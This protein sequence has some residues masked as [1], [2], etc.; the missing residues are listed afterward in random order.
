MRSATFGGVARTGDRSGG[1]AVRRAGGDRQH[2][3]PDTRQC[4]HVSDVAVE[5]A[6]VSG[7]QHG[8]HRAAECTLGSRLALL[9]RR[10]RRWARR[11]ATITY[12]MYLVGTV[13]NFCTMHASLRTDA[14][15]QQTSAMAAGITDHIWSVDELLHYRVP[16]PRWEPPRRRGRRSKALQALIDRWCPHHRLA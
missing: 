10:T 12:G 16:P 15:H 3:S 1:E 5:H 9:G 4:V 7:A 11:M 13:Y 6:R 14:K 8:V 2:P